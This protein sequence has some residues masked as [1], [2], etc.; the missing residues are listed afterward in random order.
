MHA[1]AIEPSSR[2]GALCRRMLSS[3]RKQT[4]NPPS[5]GS[6]CRAERN[7]LGAVCHSATP[8]LSLSAY[9]CDGTTLA[10]PCVLVGRAVGVA[11]K[12]PRLPRRRVVLGLA[13]HAG[14]HRRRAW[15]GVHRLGQPCL[16]RVPPALPMQRSAV[17]SCAFGCALR[18][19]AAPHS[20]RR[21]RRGL[22]GHYSTCHLTPL[23]GSEWL[24][25]T[26]TCPSKAELSGAVPCQAANDAQHAR[27]RG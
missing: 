6:H 19:A 3:M 10:L 17:P 26:C 27:V 11:H 8:A 12:H 22:I 15:L 25:T 1:P 24:A 18:C 21:C 16:S 9:A 20:H 23:R 14:E 7:G 4:H 5:L 2:C 13:F